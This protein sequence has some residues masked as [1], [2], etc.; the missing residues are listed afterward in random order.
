MQYLE[1]SGQPSVSG[2][3]PRR[4]DRAVIRRSGL[5]VGKVLGTHGGQSSWIIEGM[6][7]A[8]DQ[9]A[10]VVSMSLGSEQPTNCK[11]PMSLATEEL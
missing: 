7:W 4:R 9:G 10:D 8:I 11:D 3:A 2:F 6:E 1:S 5:L